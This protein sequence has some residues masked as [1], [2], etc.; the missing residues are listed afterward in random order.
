MAAVQEV[1]VPA[2][3]IVRGRRLQRQE[4]LASYIFLLPASI[5]FSVFMIFPVLFSI[6]LSFTRWNLLEPQ[7]TFVGLANYLALLADAGFIRAL[8]NT[9]YYAGGSIPLSMLLAL[10]VALLLNQKVRGIAAY[11]LAYFSP[12]VTSTVAVAIVWMWIF[13]PYNGVANYALSLVGLQPLRWL[14]DPRWAMPALIIMRVWQ[15]M[16]Y[17]VVVYLAGLQN[18]PQTYYEAARIDGASSLA[19]FRHITLPLLSPS[20]FFILVMS[21]ISSF[22]V[23]TQIHVMTQGGPLQSTSVIVYTIYQQAFEGYR[24]G[25]ASA[26]AL[27]LFVVIFVL[28]LAQTKWVQRRVH[29]E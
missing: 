8:L 10:G 6:Y 12:M 23:F 21:I 22:Q 24:M 15:I 9:L 16:G 29:Y 14:F 19:L 1:G 17:N 26:M 27:V 2:P 5:I 4:A 13:D 11:R 3:R 7:K 28:T 25:Y 20:S 18:I